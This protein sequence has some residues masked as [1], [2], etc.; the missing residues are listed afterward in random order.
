MGDIQLAP[1]EVGGKDVLA[2]LLAGLF[3]KHCPLCKQEVHRQG[4]AAVQRFGRWFCSERHA[5]LYE[6]ELYEALRAVRRRHAACHGGHVPLPEAVDMDFPRRQ[7]AEQECA[8]GGAGEQLAADSP[9]APV[10]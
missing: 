4:N 1:K 10:P 6:M 9:Q 5:D 7:V 8:E 3:H 2:N